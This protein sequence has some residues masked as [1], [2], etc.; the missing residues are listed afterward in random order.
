MKNII[1]SDL[2]FHKLNIR[3]Y[4]VAVLIMIALFISSGFDKADDAMIIPLHEIVM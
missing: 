4:I 2:Y 3:I 1:K